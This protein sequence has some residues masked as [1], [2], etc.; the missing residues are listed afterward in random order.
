MEPFV[1]SIRFPRF[2][3]LTPGLALFFAHPI[4]VITGPNGSNKSS[5]LRAIQCCP[6]DYDLG[7]YWFET[8]LDHIAEGQPHRYIHSYRLPSGLTAEVIKTRVARRGRRREYFETRTPT[9]R[10]GMAQMPGEGARDPKDS[11]YRSSTRWRPIEKPVLY[12]DFRSELPAYDIFYNFHD[13]LPEDVTDHGYKRMLGKRKELIRRRSR[14]LAD[15]IESGISSLIYHRVE[16]ILEPARR[17]P[18]AEIDEISK[19]LGRTYDE[20]VVVRHRFFNT[21]GYTVALRAGGHDYTE[22]FAGSGEFAVVMLV[23]KIFTAPDASLIIL[24][25]PETSLHPGAQPLLVDFIARRSLSHNHQ[26][27]ISS[28]S[29]SIVRNL[30]AESIRVLDYSPETE[31]VVL[32][33]ESSSPAEAFLRIGAVSEP[34]RIYV[35]DRLAREFVLRAARIRSEEYARSLVVT[36]T[37]GGAGNLQTRVIPMLA[38]T[39]APGFVILDGDMRPEH[40]LREFSVVPEGELLGEIAKV[41]IKEKVL[42]MDSGG[43]YREAERMA[44]AGELL[45]WAY[46]NVRYLP[47]M[48]NPESLLWELVEGEAGLGS[49]EAK[50]R[51]RARAIAKA[52]GDVTGDEI[53]FTQR[54]SL[55]A[56]PDE[57]LELLE[58]RATLEG[59]IP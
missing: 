58:L 55:A 20:V 50:S 43:E 24:D 15:A 56:L 36:A 52:G 11:N 41:G 48:G 42:W 9:T 31:Q 57:C 38:H 49:D 6:R 35:E 14:P 10:D 37:P 5:I 40:D 45:K 30:P 18:A 27:V 44:R 21:D 39:Q 34:N 32:V 51:W 53:F 7:N 8:S 3:N 33:A 19:I 47:G 23:H 22:A 54:Q 12:L 13:T 2:K 17:L 59:L 26:V 46:G 4:T 16:R 28:H 25:E 1:R 29:E